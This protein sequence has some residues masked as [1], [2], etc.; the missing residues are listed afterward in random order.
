MTKVVY[1]L[2]GFAVMLVSFIAGYQ[3][4]NNTQVSNTHTAPKLKHEPVKVIDSNLIQNMRSNNVSNAGML[5]TLTQL[6]DPLERSKG[7]YDFIQGLD[8]TE[9]QPV[10]D[11]FVKSG[12]AK[13]KKPELILLLSSWAKNDPLSAVGYVSTITDPELM[14]IVLETWITNQPE[15]ALSWLESNDSQEL[16]DG[17]YFEGVVKGLASVDMDKALSLLQQLPTSSKRSA[18]LH[19]IIGDVLVTNPDDIHLWINKFDNKLLRSEAYQIAV[20]SVAT[21]NPKEAAALISEFSDER[22]IKRTGGQVAIH[23]FQE[24]PEAAKEWIQSLPSSTID[25]ATEGALKEYILQDSHGASEWLYQLVSSKPEADFNRS[26]K[27]IIEEATHT[28]P[29]VAAEWITNLSSP[30]QQ[31]DNYW[32]VLSYWTSRNPEAAK[33]WMEFRKSEIPQLIIDKF[34]DL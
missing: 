6:H 33:E 34:N 17:A 10:I 24:N 20:N 1:I 27:T 31:H 22:T 14:N 4:A 2:I 9:F 7:I 3:F 32:S 13:F 19:K 28:N 21:T 25:Y 26:I 5:T 8:I 29:M 30:T 15:E 16:K 23:Y 12:Q 11:N 18:A